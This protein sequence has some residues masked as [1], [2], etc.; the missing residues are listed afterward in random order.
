MFPSEAKQRLRENRHRCRRRMHPQVVSAQ[1]Q[2]EAEPGDEGAAIR[3]RRVG[4]HR[5]G[6]LLRR[7]GG[8]EGENYLRG[9]EAEIAQP[10]ARCQQDAEKQDLEN[11]RIAKS[12]W[13]LPA[14]K[15]SEGG[16]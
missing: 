10:R 12:S 7:E 4:A 5:E 14:M 1:Q 16:N 13:K 3:A 6:K 2:R 8:G 11:P 15:T 9:R